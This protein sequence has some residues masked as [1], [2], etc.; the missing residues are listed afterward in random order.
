[1]NWKKAFKKG[2][3]ITLATIDAKNKP[4]AN[5]VASLGFVDG[6]I[7]IANNQMQTT[8]KNLQKSKLACLI[9]M[10][11]Q[12]YMRIKGKVEILDSGKYFEICRKADKDYPPKHA[13]LI[14][15]TEVFDLDK[16]KPVN[17]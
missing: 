14:K 13:I 10:N 15:P 7:L 6:K 2:N 1:M 8:I 12:L 5:I 17:A 16:V 4:H 3:L 9:S 11:D